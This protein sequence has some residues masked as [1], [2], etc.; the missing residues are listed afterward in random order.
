MR[1]KR[2]RKD[3]EKAKWSYPHFLGI[4]GAKQAAEKAVADAERALSMFESDTLPLQVLCDLVKQ[5][6]SRVR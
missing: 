2:L 4:E 5:L 3:V 6:P 1:G